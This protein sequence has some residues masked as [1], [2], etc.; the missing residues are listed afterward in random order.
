MQEAWNNLPGDTIQQVF[1]RIFIVL[2]LNVKSGGDNVT[3]KEQ[4]G[5]QDEDPAE[6]Y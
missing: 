5:Q 6:R 4:R 1:S 3:V 2:Q